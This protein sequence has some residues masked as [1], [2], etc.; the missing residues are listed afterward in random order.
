MFD[1]FS[2]EDF[3]TSFD[4]ILSRLFTTDLPSY[5]FFKIDFLNQAPFVYYT[6]L[7]AIPLLLCIMS[8]IILL[9]NKNNTNLI[10]KHIFYL[11]CLGFPI[12]S[13]VT[14]SFTYII[15]KIKKVSIIDMK[16]YFV[17]ILLVNI[18]DRWYGNWFHIYLNE[19]EDFGISLNSFVLAYSNSFIFS[20]YIVFLFLLLPTSNSHKNSKIL[21]SRKIR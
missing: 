7:K 17:C 6:L 19:F 16:E 9:F 21:I 15:N 4:Y 13:I 12:L 20:L 14:F 3:N 10:Q 5:L 11:F 2:L 1:N 18:I 8:F